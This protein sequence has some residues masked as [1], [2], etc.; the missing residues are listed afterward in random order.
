MLVYVSKSQ[1]V[2]KPEL[3][4]KY[5]RAQNGPEW[6]TKERDLLTNL[7]LLFYVSKFQKVFKPELNP[8][9]SPSGPKK[10]QKGPKMVPNGKQ[11]KGIY[12]LI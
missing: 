7:K 12:L 6:K 3:N 1:K 8:K 5:I 4:P 9:Y 10:G 11:K 2:F